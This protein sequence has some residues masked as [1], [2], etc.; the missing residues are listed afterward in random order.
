VL[1]DCLAE[2]TLGAIR[3]DEIHRDGGDPIDSFHGV[4]RAR[5]GHDVRSLC[6]KR[7]HD[8]QSDALAT[9][10]YDGNLLV[11]F[12]VHQPA[13][14]SRSAL[15]TSSGANLKRRGRAGPSRKTRVVCGSV[16]GGNGD[17]GKRGQCSGSRFQPRKCLLSHR[18]TRVILYGP[19]CPR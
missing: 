8:R 10:G 3:V 7:A 4:N 19:C 14:S 16:I 1:L 9:A 5:S 12:E 15:L 2:E 6:G 13:M 11:Q 18:S 17:Y